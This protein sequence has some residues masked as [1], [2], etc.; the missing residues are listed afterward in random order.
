MDSSEFLEVLRSRRSVR[1]FLPEPV[2]GNDL[3]KI[4][5]AASLAPS[6]TNK[7]NWGFVVARSGEVRHKMKEA[8]ETETATALTRIEDKL[9]AKLKTAIEPA[10]KVEAIA[11][12]AIV[13]NCPAP[14][15]RDLGTIS[16]IVF[17]TPG[18][19]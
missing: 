6:G 12:V 19:L 18:F 7:Q 9:F 4:I 13:F 10:S 17:T 16:F 14:K 2:P 15:P 11:V 5:Y 3:E 8:V 1:K